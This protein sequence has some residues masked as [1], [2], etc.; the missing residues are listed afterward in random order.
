[1]PRAQEFELLWLITT[2][3]FSPLPPAMASKTIAPFKQ[4]TMPLKAL[5][6]IKKRPIQDRPCL[7]KVAGAAW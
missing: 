1:L 5:L 6:S 4:K 7:R 2:A 3:V